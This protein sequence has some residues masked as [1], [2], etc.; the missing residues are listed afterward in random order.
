VPS[1]ASVKVWS[2]GW[3]AERAC[4]YC[5]STS[6]ILVDEPARDLLCTACGEY[7]ELKATR[8]AA[9]LRSRAGSFAAYQARFD[10]DP[11]NLLLLTYAYDGRDH[12]ARGLR[13]VPRTLVDGGLLEA[14][15]ASTLHTGRVVRLCSLLIGQ[16]P[17]LARIPVLVEGC[18][19]LASSVAGELRR[20]QSLTPCSGSQWHREVLRIIGWLNK[21]SFS[22]TELLQFRPW[23]ERCFPDASTPSQTLS[24]VLQELRD[25]RVIE[26][27]GRGEYRLLG[28]AYR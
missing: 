7:Y 13:V 22:R 23:L 25:V 27:V 28:V 12:V 1:P 9:A 4:P 17:V 26:F 8:N 2:E 15:A 19:V 10:S 14:S 11:P 3:A 18:D 6:L 21:P 5:V 24:R 16:V 20:W